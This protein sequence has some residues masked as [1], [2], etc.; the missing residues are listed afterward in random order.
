MPDIKSTI[1]EMKKTF[2]GFIS[3][4]DIAEERITDS[5]QKAF[6][7]K[8]KEKNNEEKNENRTEYP[9]TGEQ[10]QKV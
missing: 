3:W 9:R 5:Q 7:V 4:L 8:Y 6:K 10:Y 1:T 2:D